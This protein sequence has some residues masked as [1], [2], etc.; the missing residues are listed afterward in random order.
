MRGTYSSE[1]EAAFCSLLSTFFLKGKGGKEEEEEEALGLNLAKED[2][3][4]FCRLLFL[5]S[6][7]VYE[8]EGGGGQDTR[9]CGKSKPK[10]EVGSQSEYIAGRGGGKEKKRE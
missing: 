2:K 9:P 1:A 7:T 4:L 6:E 5:P 10:R 8:A 3:R